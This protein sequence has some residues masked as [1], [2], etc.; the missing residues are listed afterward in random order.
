MTKKRFMRNQLGQLQIPC[1]DIYPTADTKD[2]SQ[3][4]IFS[5]ITM[6]SA[7]WKS[8]DKGTITITFGGYNCEGCS[9]EAAWSQI[10]K[11]SNGMVPSMNLGFLDPPY[12]SF[13]FEGKKYDVPDS[14]TR[15]YCGNTGPSSCHKGWVPGATVVHEFGHALGMMHEHQ[16]NLFKSNPIRINKEAVIKYYNQIGMG[17]SGATTNV[18]DTYECS[19]GKCDYAGTKYDE[20]SIMLYYLPDDWIIG[21]NPTY[22]NFV[23]SKDD[24]GW[25]QQ[26]Y[27]LNNKNPP[28]ITVKF[29]DRNPEPWK[30]AWVK[31]MVMETYGKLIGI[32][33]IFITPQLKIKNISSTNT[34][35]N[36]GAS[37]IL[38]P[39]K[40][41]QPLAACK[42]ELSHNDKLGLG[43]GLG[44]GIPIFLIFCMFVYYYYF[45]D[46]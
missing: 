24:I 15:N 19:D 1:T 7:T 6:T 2:A 31:K 23:L 32:N 43:L 9:V 5:A 37:P 10:G 26:I 3:S 29:I 41:S 25:L 39:N 40:T 35:A 45:K 13:E 18:L 8:G 28:E 16:N 12:K 4:L 42:M 21:K 20:K 27:P 34:G 44:L 14:A 38:N 30:I 36:A 46:R 22:P 17:E 33:W 11:Q